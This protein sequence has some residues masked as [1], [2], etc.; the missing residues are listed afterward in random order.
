MVGIHLN[1]FFDMI[2]MIFLLLRTVRSLN[3]SC[4]LYIIST[5]VRDLSDKECNFNIQ[6][7]VYMHFA[8]LLSETNVT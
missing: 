1:L 7:T 6:R 3:I 5:H 4:A 8:V 2:T